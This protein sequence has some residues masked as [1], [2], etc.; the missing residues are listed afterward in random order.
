M[1]R[2]ADV[3]VA[4]GLKTARMGGGGLRGAN[5][6][7]SVKRCRPA[8]RGET[9]G[10][11]ARENRG[12]TNPSW[13]LPLPGTSRRRSRIRPRPHLDRCWG[14]SEAAPP[15]SK[16]VRRLRHRQHVRQW[17]S[18]GVKIAVPVAVHAPNFERLTCSAQIAD[19][20]GAGIVCHRLRLRFCHSIRR[21]SPSPLRW[22]QTALRGPVRQPAGPLARHHSPRPGR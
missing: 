12:R 16:S 17:Q 3:R 6:T 10:L 2:C 20:N 8:K 15:A 11:K 14:V 21:Q 5:R 4:S 19:G 7:G 1:T 18:S 13:S 9:V 22:H